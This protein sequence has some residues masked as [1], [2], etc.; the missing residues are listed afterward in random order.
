MATTSTVPTVKAAL[1]SL[2][3]TAIDDADTVHVTQ[4][5]PQEALI[6]SQQVIVGAVSYSSEIANL[7]SGR[8]QRDETY[9]IEVVFL[10]AFPGGTPDEAE[11]AV[12]AHFA[13][14]EDI[15]ADDPTLGVADLAWATLGQV[16]GDVAIEQS[17][18]IAWI[19]ADVNCKARLV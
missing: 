17:G 11:T 18:P 10:A 12:W 16:E 13:H 5:R 4:G 8:K 9:S 6:N 19:T 7:K 3:V 1:A 15:L 2:L 14:L